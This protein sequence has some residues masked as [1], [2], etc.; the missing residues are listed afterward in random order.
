MIHREAPKVHLF[1][2][3][4]DPNVFLYWTKVLKEYFK[5]RQLI[6]NA[7]K[8]YAKIKLQ[9]DAKAWWKEVEC[10]LY[11]HSPPWKEMK[12]LM[13]DKY[14]HGRDQFSL[15]GERQFEAHWETL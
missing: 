9:G 3:N 6:G 10:Q 4:K 2:G 15:P 1:Y 11:Q 14:V 8:D 5:W 7:C 12:L 13:E